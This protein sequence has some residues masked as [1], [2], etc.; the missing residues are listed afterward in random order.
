MF[1]AGPV[2]VERTR[3][4]CMLYM[5]VRNTDHLQMPSHTPEKVDFGQAK[6]RRS[7]CTAHDNKTMH[8]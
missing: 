7:G 2:A 3:E 4:E 8:E 6:M 1:E 5:Q